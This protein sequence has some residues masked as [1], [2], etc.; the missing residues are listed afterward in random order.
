MQERVK[1]LEGNISHLLETIS[2]V[3]CY[4]C[5]WLRHV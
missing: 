1:E 3:C 5:C 2:R 4:V